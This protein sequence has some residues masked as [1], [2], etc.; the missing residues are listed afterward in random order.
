MGGKFA[1]GAL[2]GLASGLAEAVSANMLEGIAK[3]GMTGAEAVAARTLARVVGS[4]IRTAASPGDP[5]QAFASAFLDDVFKQ[6]DT[7]TPVT[8][9]AFDDEGRLNLG[10]VDPSASPEQQ[11]QQLAA[12]LQRQ[13]IPV[14]QANLMAVQALGNVVNGVAQLP[15]VPAPSSA[16]GSNPAPALV[17][18]L[19]FDDDGNL[20]PGVVTLDASFEDQRAQLQARLVAQGLSSS[21]AEAAAVGYY[22][23]PLII[24]DEAVRE[25]AQAQNTDEARLDIDEFEPGSSYEL[26]ADAG[27]PGVVSDAGPP[28]PRWLKLSES[29]R[30]L[31][32]VDTPFLVERNQLFL[33]AQIGKYEQL[34]TQARDNG[35]VLL[36]RSLNTE[37]SM[38]E[39]TLTRL[40]ARL[41]EIDYGVAALRYADRLASKPNVA[42]TRQEIVAA[43]QRLVAGASTPGA[44]VDAYVREQMASEDT[45]LLLT[46]M[47]G[48]SIGALVGQDGTGAGSPRLQ[49]VPAGSSKPT[50]LLITNPKHHPNSVS[51]EPPNAAKLYELSISDKSGVRWSKDADGTIHRFSKPSNGETHWNGSTAGISPISLQNIPVEIR[52]LL[53]GGKP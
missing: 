22:K 53:A 10:I 2:A 32:E 49:R 26:L 51:P 46:I 34:E 35:D 4:A 15:Q 43:T 13:G 45:K 16:V 7:S 50:S 38:F 6:I 17:A 25:A 27:L 11:A 37:R 44:A 19:A 48:G 36:A 31:T 8:Q 14:A 9:T 33:K 39:S 41:L 42:F 29:L 40:D 24:R 21:D 5:G 47:G 20:M 3:S 28:T 18:Q 23:A 52:R 1:D 12:Q 30:R